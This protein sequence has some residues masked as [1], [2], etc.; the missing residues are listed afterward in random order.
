M[1]CEAYREF[2]DG[3]DPELVQKDRVSYLRK[4][5][6]KRKDLEKKLGYIS[7]SESEDS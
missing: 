6:K 5:I 2:R 3:K 4:V 1:S 7:D